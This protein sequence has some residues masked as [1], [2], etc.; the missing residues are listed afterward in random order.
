MICLRYH[1][2]ILVILLGLVFASHPLF[3]KKSQEAKKGKC[4][5][6]LV[7]EG[8]I[9]LSIDADREECERIQ[10]KDIETSYESEIVSKKTQP[11]GKKR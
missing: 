5:V 1:L 2:V 3:G 6:S 10:G 7:T 4:Q 8:S 9:F 11:D